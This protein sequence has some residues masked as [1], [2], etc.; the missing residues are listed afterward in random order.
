MRTHP[1]G[2]ENFVVHVPRMLSTPLAHR[3]E[4]NDKHM[5]T[6]DRDICGIPSDLRSVS[7]DNS[8]SS[9]SF[10]SE[11]ITNV[12][13]ENAFNGCS[14]SSSPRSI[15]KTYWDK[16]ESLPQRPM[17]PTDKT[18]STRSTSPETSPES[19]EESTAANSNELVLKRSERVESSRRRSIFGM[20]ESTPFI[21]PARPYQPSPLVR[22]RA[23]SAPELEKN[24]S[25]PSCLRST[26]RKPRSSSVSFDAK[27]SV[28]TFNPPK[29]NWAADGWSKWFH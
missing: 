12:D 3:V 25:L 20:H 29:E 15:F 18:Y 13:Q 1:E 7:S 28:I 8:L 11:S 24:R 10:E 22:T 17:T 21:I 14:V 16:C 23:K 5:E 4:S 26:E 27:V 6:G 19:D 9:L 2:S